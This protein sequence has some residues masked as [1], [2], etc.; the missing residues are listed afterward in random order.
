[1]PDGFTDKITGALLK[2]DV[3]VW[4]ISLPAVAIVSELPAGFTP[5]YRC[6]T[7]G[8]MVHRA[9]RQPDTAAQLATPPPRKRRPP[10]EREVSFNLDSC[11]AEE[12]DEEDAAVD[13]PMEAIMRE[14]LGERKPRANTW[15]HFG[16]RKSSITW[17]QMIVY[18]FI[19]NGN[20]I[21]LFHRMLTDRTVL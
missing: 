8:V 21:I 4:H 14:P 17:V 20:T 10:V 5:D 7:D 16:T 2:R 19:T 15:S 11:A 1:M 12:T 13:T 6:T 9:L 18:S 3:S